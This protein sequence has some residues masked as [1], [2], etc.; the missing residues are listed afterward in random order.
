MSSKDGDHA[1]APDDVKAKFRE[2]LARKQGKHEEHD[3]GRASADVHTHT[4]P[5]KVQR[6]FRRKSG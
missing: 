2:A 6:Q 4:G 1:A 5:A 3:E